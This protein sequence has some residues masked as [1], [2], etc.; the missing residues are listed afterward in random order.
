[1]TQSIE[2]IPYC[3]DQN[4][5]SAFNIKAPLLF[6]LTAGLTVLPHSHAFEVVLRS[7]TAAQS[8]GGGSADQVT[9]FITHR[10]DW[11]HIV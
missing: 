11:V 3:L 2:D 5:E 7:V 1:M 6:S 10:E 4:Y 8:G 9:P